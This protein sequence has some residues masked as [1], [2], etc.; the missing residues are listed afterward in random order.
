MLFIAGCAPGKEHEKK[1]GLFRKF[2]KRSML[3]CRYIGTDREQLTWAWT[4]TMCWRRL[5]HP[6]C[7]RVST[8]TTCAMLPSMVCVAC[9]V[10]RGRH[11]APPLRQPHKG[12]GNEISQGFE[13]CKKT[14]THLNTRWWTTIVGP[15]AEPSLPAARYA[16]RRACTRR[17]C[18]H[19]SSAAMC[20]R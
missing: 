2:S 20:D 11:R 4:R 15:R 13:A 5:G 7:C 19:T 8:S 6:V 14:H 16:V 12:Q 3:L 17:G 1:V 18:R 10:G 9:R